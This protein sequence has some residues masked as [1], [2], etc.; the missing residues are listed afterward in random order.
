MKLKESPLE[1]ALRR[2]SRLAARGL[3]TQVIE[4]RH[5][6]AVLASWVL[7]ER[8]L[9]IL[10]SILRALV[11]QGLQEHS[12]LAQI[13]VSLGLRGFTSTR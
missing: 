4:L 1:I 2:G 6:G 13:L 10:D 8:L 9:S 12:C 7:A 11:Q 3:A 5:P